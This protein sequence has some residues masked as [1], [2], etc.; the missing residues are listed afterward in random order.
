M[1]LT[2]QDMKNL[3]EMVEDV[4][5]RRVDPRF[6]QVD[7]RF[8]QVDRRFDLLEERFDVLEEQVDGLKSQMA[9]FQ[10]DMSVIKKMA[11]DHAFEIERLN[12][13]TA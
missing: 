4:I 6:E 3:R 9:T 5:T 12:Q 11:G 7:R 1:S 2:A 10:E 13:R 8:E